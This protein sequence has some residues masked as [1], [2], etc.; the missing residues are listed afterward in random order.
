MDYF[1]GTSPS[2]SQ[3]SPDTANY[4]QSNDHASGAIGVTAQGA[5]SNMMASAAAPLAPTQS[6]S[7]E[8]NTAGTGDMFDFSTY[9]PLQANVIDQLA[10]S[11]GLTGVNT[12]LNPAQYVMQQSQTVMPQPQQPQQYYAM[13][14]Q[15]GYVPFVQPATAALHTLGQQQAA[16]VVSTTTTCSRQQQQPYSMPAQPL[17]AAH[18]LSAQA[19]A[20]S[21]VDDGTAKQQAVYYSSLPSVVSASTTGSTLGDYDDDD[22]DNF[23][24]KRPHNW[25]SMTLEEKR[26]WERNMREQQR[27]HRISSQIKELRSVLTESHVPFKPNKY[28]ILLSVAEYI[29]QLQARAIMLD[30]EHRKLVDTIRQTSEMVN[31]GTTPEPDAPTSMVNEGQGSNVSSGADMLFVK[32]V[33]YQCVFEQCTAAIGIAAL[34]GRILDCNNEFENILGY[35]KEELLKHSLFTVMQNHEEVYEAMGEMLKADDITLGQDL[36]ETNEE[37]PPMYWSGVVGQTHQNVS[38]MNV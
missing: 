2:E 35:S 17:T 1:V 36:V 15:Q 10:A 19:A 13:P 23:E 6:A 22:D 31:S 5:S 7:A 14:Q 11:A 16:S 27:S 33:D 29:K 30:A 20:I 8:S 38:A 37:K 9:D 25:D 32:G 18:V 34:D 21:G 24:K 28:S 12:A 26:R 4:Q 3:D